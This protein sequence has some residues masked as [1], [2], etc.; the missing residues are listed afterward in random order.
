MLGCSGMLAKDTICA[1]EARLSTIVLLR[2]EHQPW[3]LFLFRSI[4]THVVHKTVLSQTGSLHGG[5]SLSGE[6]RQ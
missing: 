1:G 6:A 4:C 3:V 5:E 2:N